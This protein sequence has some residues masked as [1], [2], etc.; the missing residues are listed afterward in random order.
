M[1][2]AVRADRSL[3]PCS[4]ATRL[5]LVEVRV[6]RPTGGGRAPAAVCLVLD[7][8]GSMEGE[9]LALAITAAQQAVAALDERDRFCAVA[10]DTAVDVMVPNTRATPSARLEACARL[11]ALRASGSTDLCSG[12]LTGAAEVGRDLPDDAIGR[13]V[14]LT[15][16]QANNGIVDPEQLA[17]HA[18]ELRLRRVTTST[19]GLGEGFNE[20]LLGRVAE[21]GGGN[22]AFAATARDLPGIVGRELGEVM[23]VAARDA[24]LVLELPPGVCVESLNDYADADAGSG[25]ARRT[26][27]LGSLAGGQVLTA[28]FRLRLPAGMPASTLAV[29]VTVAD[30][31]GALAGSQPTR[32]CWTRVDDA[33]ATTEA[34]DLEVVRAAAVLDAARARREALALNEAGRLADAGAA[35]DAAVGRIAALAPGDDVVRGVVDQLAAERERYAQPMH[36]YARKDIFARS[37]MQQKRSM[38]GEAER[39]R[40]PQP[41]TG[42]PLRALATTSRL[43]DALA[44]AQRALQVTGGLPSVEVDRVSAKALAGSLPLA[45]A[46]EATLVAA[47][48][49][50]APGITL[51]F[52]EQVLDDGWFS[53]WHGV[54]RTAVVSCAGFTAMTGL[55][56][57]AFVAYELLFHGLRAHSDRYDPLALAHRR[58]RGCLFDL[59]LDKAEIAVKLQAGH[60]CDECLAA[61]S[62]LGVDARATGRSWS[63]VQALAH[64]SLAP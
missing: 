26:F 62:H 53:H 64:P 49:R 30:R 13:C 43:L 19:I 45:R 8:S 1:P 14:V 52:V 48:A 5:L 35:V 37:L 23:S 55:T 4:A 40:L 10:F 25:G 2:F 18:R 57:E 16:G 15:D 9:K 20:F 39:Q 38:M 11:A 34:P 56:L 50:T 59:C 33:T 27:V 12:W 24:Q 58:S 51:L 31:D 29:D 60:I 32:A 21:Q 42:V 6:P 61:L 7:R 28:L 54:E 44:I 22:F 63:A 36:S 47:V 17:R 3:L 46:D 41:P